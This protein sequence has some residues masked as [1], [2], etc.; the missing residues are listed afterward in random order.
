MKRTASLLIGTLLLAGCAGSV[1]TPYTVHKSL[2]LN[3]RLMK[4]VMDNGAPYKEV[5]LANGEVIHYWRSDLS[6]FSPA[7]R[8]R[9]RDMDVCEI[10]LRTDKNRVI[11]QIQIIEDSSI[12]FGVLK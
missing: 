5:K 8:R 3:K 9:W 11:R 6:S 10:A 4:F 12:C 1:S 2:Y 7:F